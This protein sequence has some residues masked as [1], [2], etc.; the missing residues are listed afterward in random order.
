MGKRRHKDSRRRRASSADIRFGLLVLAIGG[1]V[2]VLLSVLVDQLRTGDWRGVA[3]AGG[4]IALL[5]GIAGYSAA[6]R[7]RA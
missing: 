5:L 2:L 3:L 4:A 7:R 1:V 6:Q